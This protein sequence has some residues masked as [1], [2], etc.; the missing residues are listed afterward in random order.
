MEVTREVS[1]GVNRTSGLGQATDGGRREDI[2]SGRIFSCCEINKNP[3]AIIT[4]SP[5]K[6]DMKSFFLM[7]LVYQIGVEIK[8]PS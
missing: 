8:L 2:F 1:T 7:L 4:A 6:I 5:M 3:A